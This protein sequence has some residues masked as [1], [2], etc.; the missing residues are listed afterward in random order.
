MLT[1][2]EQEKKMVSHE[3]FIRQNISKTMENSNKK[4]KDN[5]ERTMKEAMFQLLSG[6]GEK[7]KL[8]DIN[9][10]DL[11]KYIDQYLK[12][13]YHHKNKSINQSYIEYGESSEATSIMAPTSMNDADQQSYYPAI[14]PVGVYDQNPNFNHLSHNQYQQQFGYPIVAQ[15]KFD[16]PGQNQEQREEWLDDQGKEL[17]F[18]G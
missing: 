2:S 4:M 12:E 17:S 3:S 11:C 9:R 5:A 10:E 1:K 18:D 13:L 8:T 7:L 14:N 16:N 6:K 15:D